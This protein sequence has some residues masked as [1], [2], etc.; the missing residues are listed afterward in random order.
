MNNITDQADH[1]NALAILSGLISKCNGSL[2]EGANLLADDDKRVEISTTDLAE[3]MRRLGHEIK[4]AHAIACT[5]GNTAAGW[6]VEPDEAIVYQGERSGY[7]TELVTGI[8]DKAQALSDMM[9][10]AMR[11]ATNDRTIH[12]GTAHTALWGIHGLILEVL[13]VLQYDSVGELAEAAAA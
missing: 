6:P 7:P 12:D 13:A 3:L 8:L 4:A 10:L 9:Y 1:T 5:I 2:C 11:H